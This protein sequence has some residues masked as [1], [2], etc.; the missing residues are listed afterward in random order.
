MGKSYRY[1]S[2]QDSDGTLE[3][4]KSEE[5]EIARYMKETYF[6]S[7]EKIKLSIEICRGSWNFYTN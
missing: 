6:T 3:E 1:P 7:D 4:G 5:E 2:D